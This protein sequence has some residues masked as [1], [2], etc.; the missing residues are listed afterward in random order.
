MGDPVAALNRPAYR[1]VASGGKAAATS[2]DGDNGEFWFNSSCF[3]FAKMLAWS[4]AKPA[5][6]EKNGKK[7]EHENQQK[8]RL[9]FVKWQEN[10]TT[11][12]KN[13]KQ[14]KGKLL[15]LKL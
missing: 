2:D 3:M 8:E 1:L 15:R 14:N 5:E 10:G 11:T 9:Q 4:A 12:K 6:T 7:K 13:K